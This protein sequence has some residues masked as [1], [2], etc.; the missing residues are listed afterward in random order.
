M[1]GIFGYK[2]SSKAADIVLSGLKKLD[3][4]GYDSWGI[5]INFDHQ[6]FLKKTLGKLVILKK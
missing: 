3:Y 1:C 5:A 2:G 6:I 4:R